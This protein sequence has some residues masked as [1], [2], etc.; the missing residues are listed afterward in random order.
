MK[1]R[2]APMTQDEHQKKTRGKGRGSNFFAASEGVW[3]Q[4]WKIPTANRLN[5]VACYLVLLAGT[6][7]DHRLTKWSAKAC[8]QYVGIGKPRAKVAIE[9][10]IAAGLVKRMNESERL[11][12]QYEMP[13]LP[14]AEEP[15]FLPVAFVTGLSGEAS[16]LRRIRETGDALAL[17][18]VVDLY[19]LTVLD[20]T[21]GVSL[22]CF[23]GGLKTGG[24]ANARKLAEVGAHTVWGL[25]QG[26]Y[27][28]AGGNWTSVHRINSKDA[29]VAW[30]PFWSRLNLLKQIGA[31]WFEPWVFDSQE[32]DAEPLFPL[33]SSGFYQLAEPE[34]EAK[35][36]ALAYNTCRALVSEDRGYIFDNASCDYYL[37]LTAHRQA[38]AYR[39][40]LRL[41]VEADTPGRR[42]AWY[43]RRTAIEK[44]TVGYQKLLLDIEQGN[45][46]RPLNLT[47]AEA[48]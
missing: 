41:R 20:P 3:D 40:V 13:A 36:T 9:E 25:N 38:P 42:L 37:P 33:D 23:R 10:L 27:R 21:Y 45:F 7:S 48:A 30:E 8:E 12:P 15:I 18:M 16:I 4:L 14:L 26:T 17:R 24:E 44:F 5:L 43:K 1:S 29:E 46:D 34:G 32:I 31:V 11:K 19:K 6:G 22:N 2:N 28:S 47:N 35:L 39:E